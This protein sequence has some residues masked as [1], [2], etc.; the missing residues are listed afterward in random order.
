MAPRPPEPPASPLAPEPPAPPPLPLPPPPPAAPPDVDDVAAP[1]D[2]P[3]PPG[4]F[5]DDDVPVVP[6]GVA[7][8]P[9]PPP[10][11]PLDTA[12]LPPWLPDDVELAS[13][14][15]FCCSGYELEPD[16]PISMQL[17][18]VCKQILS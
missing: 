10:D 1:D 8:L 3:P 15:S 4:L 13:S 7:S 11:T 17:A 16:I 2:D 9:L 14:R 6:V 12:P 5:D 18:T